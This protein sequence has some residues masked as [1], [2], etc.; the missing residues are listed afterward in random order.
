[1]DSFR[2][3]QRTVAA[4][5]G[6][7]GCPW[8]K[9]QT[10][11][12]LRPYLLE[13]THEVLDAMDALPEGALPPGDPAAAAFREELGDLL[14]QVVLHAQLA[15]ESG[16]FTLEDIAADLDKKLK[17]RHPHVFGNEKFATAEAVKA[18]WSEQKKREKP[19][20]AG[21]LSGIPS[22]LPALA[23]AEK[24][25]DKVSRVGFQWPDLAGPMAK[26]EEEWAELKAEIAGD[27][28][29]ATNPK[30]EAELG[31][32]LFCVAN[33]AYLLGVHPEDAL[34]GMLARFSTRFSHVE[35]ELARQGKAW[36][37]TTLA[38]MDKLWDE[39]KRKKR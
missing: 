35:A 5:R 12:T 10:H 4:L 19:S 33:I 34:R 24:I 29:A 37:S 39:A 26:L 18:N 1:M 2:E 17:R 28:Q 21:V 36:E 32:L 14:F 8:D 30:L 6:D 15:A 16:A 9:A 22:T 23:R 38:E 11:R 3:L 20:G 13:E 25:I 31:D 7:G 27:P